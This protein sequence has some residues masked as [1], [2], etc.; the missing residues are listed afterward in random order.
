MNFNRKYSLSASSQAFPS[1]I[2]CSFPQSM[3]V[4]GGEMKDSFLKMFANKDRQ[5][6]LYFYFVRVY[7]N[8]FPIFSIRIHDLIFSTAAVL[9]VMFTQNK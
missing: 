6:L 2:S 8:C 7:H 3:E 4:E 9:L 5:V 1:N